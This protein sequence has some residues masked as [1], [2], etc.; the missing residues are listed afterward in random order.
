MRSLV[1]TDGSHERDDVFIPDTL[2][3]QI[4]KVL[5]QCG[6]HLHGNAQL[7]G[8]R[9]CAAASADNAK[10]LRSYQLAGA[11][12]SQKDASG[13]TP[14]H[15]AALHNRTDATL[16]L[17]NHGADL[18]C[19]DMLGQTAADLAQAVRA[20]DVARFLGSSVQNGAVAVRSEN[21]SANA[22]T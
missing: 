6:A 9:M 10:R 19:V 21:L 13:R 20:A 12:L 3:F 8:E 2:I 16:F 15:F 11:D 1:L 22:S 7:I 5:L 18:C 17:L 4:I 14:L